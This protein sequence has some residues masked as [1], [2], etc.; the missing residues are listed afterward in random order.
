MSFE[1]QKIL[2][3]T[4]KTLASFEEESG[5]LA[6]LKAKGI[7]YA[8]SPYVF[9]HVKLSDGSILVEKHNGVIVS[10]EKIRDILQGASK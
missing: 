10:P 8:G 3:T 6:Y 1:I 4:R 5:L 7:T 9:T 2:K